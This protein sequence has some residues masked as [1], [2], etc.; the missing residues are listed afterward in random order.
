M[1]I[2]CKSNRIL[3]E[4]CPDS[5]WVCETVA[6]NTLSLTYTVRELR[7]SII[8]RIRTSDSVMIS[9]IM[10][11]GM[12]VSISGRGGIHKSLNYPLGL[13]ERRR[14]K[15]KLDFR[16]YWLQI[17]RSRIWNSK[18]SKLYNTA[19]LETHEGKSYYHIDSLTNELNV[20]F[21]LVKGEYVYQLVIINSLGAS[22]L[23]LKIRIEELDIALP[24]IRR[25]FFTWIGRENYLKHFQSPWEV[26][27]LND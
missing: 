24:L 7:D 1:T 21:G 10:A 16:R 12:T 8:I 13:F 22:D 2:S 3:R 6:I 20:S 25:R 14:F 18:L 23:D 26:S 11:L 19:A 15:S 9:R 5:T 27:I 4:Q 17:N